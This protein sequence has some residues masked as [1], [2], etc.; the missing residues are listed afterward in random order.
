MNVFEEIYS[1]SD[2]FEAL[3]LIKE[4]SPDIL[5]CDLKMAEMDGFE[6]ID[7]VNKEADLTDVKIIA[8]SAY[9]SVEE[10]KRLNELGVD[11]IVKPLNEGSIL[12]IIS[13][14]PTKL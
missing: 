6:F 13:D 4:Q 12:K 2:P 5:F 10:K 14:I 8:M 3:T 7:L 9:V 11:Y 1:A